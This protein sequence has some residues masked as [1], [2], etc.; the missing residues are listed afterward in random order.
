MFKIGKLLLPKDKEDKDGKDMVELPN[1]IS[2]VF[3]IMRILPIVQCIQKVFY[4]NESK[5]F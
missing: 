5:H 3:Y 2:F 1:G 4:K